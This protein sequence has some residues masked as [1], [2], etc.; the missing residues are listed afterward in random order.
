MTI[1]LFSKTRQEYGDTYLTSFP[2]GP[3]IPWRPLSLGDYLKYS[4]DY[5]RKL[6]PTSILEDEIFKKCVIEK[7]FI[8]QMPFMKAGIISVVVQN[9]WEMSGPV[10]ITEFNNDL[11][12]ARTILFSDGTRAIQDLVQVIT[13]AFPYKPEEIYA[14][15]YETFL[16]R[17]A[18]AEKKL[19]EMGMLKEPIEMKDASEETQKKKKPRVEFRDLNHIE[20]PKGPP[21][22]E[23][24]SPRIDA[25]ALWE[26]QQKTPKKP[27]VEIKKEE[28]ETPLSSKEKPWKVS[29]VLEAKNKKKIDF[30][31][32]SRDADDMSL[33]NDEKNAH[34]DVRAKI[35]EMKTKDTRNNLIK[36]AQWV[37]ADLLAELE[38]KK[39]G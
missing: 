24:L 26:K 4:R 9:I 15:D 29:P 2:D 18:M 37:Y 6:I 7:T 11:E 16:L 5:A 22:E 36:T 38:K 19:L 10:G 14:M 27:P 12:M 23:T 35:L 32:D 8:R 17:V 34:P 13:M 28:M 21:P 20:Q 31:A 25:K 39:Q 33:D 3:V 30:A 1:S